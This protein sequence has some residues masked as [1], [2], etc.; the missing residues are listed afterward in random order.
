MP[1]SPPRLTALGVAAVSLSTASLAVGLALLS[2]PLLVVA[3]ASGALVLACRFHASGH[4]EGFVVERSLPRRARAGE[5]F[6]TEIRLRPGPR[7]PRDAEARFTDPLAPAVRG[8]LFDATAALRCTGI[9]HRRGPLP[10]RPWTLTSTWPLG[11]FLTEQQGEF[12]DDH[13]T[14][15][16]PKPWLPPRLRQRLERI[17]EDSADHPLEPSDPL[18]E[19]RLLREFRNG[20]PVRG[21]YWPASLRSGRLQFAETEPPRP[22]P[23]TC[24]LLL[25]SYEA[26]G[27]VIVPEGWE[28]ILRL[29]AGLLSHFRHEGAPL[30][31]SMAPGPVLRLRE[32]AQFLEAL[33]AL[34]LSRRHPL[35]RLDAVFPLSGGSAQDDPFLGCDEVFVLGDG[36]LDDWEIAARSHFPRCT[37]IDPKSLSIGPG[38]GLVVRSRTLT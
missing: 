36:N 14:L 20:D 30:V 2:A 26:P 17:S 7:F 15:V 25:H 9:A 16:L 23:P 1:D 6:P 21:L 27:T 28:R 22:R 8:R 33:D 3:L 19:F 13:A 31:F 11:L 24:G 12:R 10:R 29:A 38:I 37:C 4:L 32:A 35:A 18:A 5:S 34:A